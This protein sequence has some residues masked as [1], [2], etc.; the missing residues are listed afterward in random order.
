M[1]ILLVL[2][3]ISSAPALAYLLMPRTRRQGAVR[4]LPALSGLLLTASAFF[5]VAVN[6][7]WVS[8]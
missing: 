6:V 5:V 3:G 4:L 7:G 8:P 2:L 1:T